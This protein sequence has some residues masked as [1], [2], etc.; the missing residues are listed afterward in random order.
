MKKVLKFLGYGIAALIIVGVIAGVIA[1]EPMPTPLKSGAAAD[2]LARKMESAVNK[3]AWDQTRFVSWKFLSGTSYLWDKDKKA[4]V[5]EWGD[6]KVLLS[7]PDQTGMAYVGGQ[8]VTD[9]ATKQKLLDKA[10][11][12]FA[13]DSF[14]LCA[15][16]K[17]FDP[18]TRREIATNK[19][20]EEGLLVHYSSGGV[21]PGDSYLWLLDNTGKPKAW[22]M[23]VNIIPVGG[24]QFTWEDWS[25]GANEPQI[26]QQHDGKLLNV[27]IKDLSYPNYTDQNNPL[28]ALW[29]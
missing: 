20:G 3:A 24:L 21:T 19:A 28:K 12:Q 2:E 25:G 9:A 4:V 26:A 14:W 1:N 22:Q 17:A 23:W 8:L 16:M 29:D 7:T 11:S 10:W 15:P 6:N 18:G 27:P 13:N 5:V